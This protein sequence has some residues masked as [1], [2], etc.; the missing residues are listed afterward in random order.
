MIEHTYDPAIERYHVLNPGY[1]F[2]VLDLLQIRQTELPEQYQS[3]ELYEVEMVIE[4]W[5]RVLIDEY[6]DKRRLHLTFYGVQ[7]LKLA[8]GLV[9]NGAEVTIHSIKHYQW[10]RLKYHIYGKRDQMDLSFYCRGFDVV[11]EET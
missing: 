6:E 2:D 1:L 9:V 4:L 5:L 8:A 7:C 11:L 3:A 10:E